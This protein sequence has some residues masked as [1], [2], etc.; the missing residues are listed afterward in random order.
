MLARPSSP[1]AWT[2]RFQRF[3]IRWMLRRGFLVGGSTPPGTAGITRRGITRAVICADGR[4]YDCARP[5]SHHQEHIMNHHCECHTVRPRVVPVAPS[6]EYPIEWD[7]RDGA[8]T[9]SPWVRRRGWRAVTSTEPSLSGR[10]PRHLPRLQHVADSPTPRVSSDAEF[11]RVRLLR[12]DQEIRFCRWRSATGAGRRSDH[13]VASSVSSLKVR[14]MGDA[15]MAGECLIGV[16]GASSAFWRITLRFQVVRPG[17]LNGRAR[18]DR[19]L[20]SS[21]RIRPEESVHLR[22]V[23]TRGLPLRPAGVAVRDPAQCQPFWWGSGQR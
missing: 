17:S 3:A 5:R 16:S 21:Y 9:G 6:P 20:P 2:A 1:M 19:Q 18:C 8:R 4:P 11:L 23:R 7:Q 14:I 15:P 10:H 13:A 12:D 22:E